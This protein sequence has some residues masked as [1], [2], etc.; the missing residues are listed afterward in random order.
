MVVVA[1][2]I[3]LLIGGLTVVTAMSKRT[4]RMPYRNRDIPDNKVK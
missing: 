3:A 2:G 4:Q 1:A